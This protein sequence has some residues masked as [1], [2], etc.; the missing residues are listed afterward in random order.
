M[1]KLLACIFCLALFF[2]CG[3]KEEAV[4]S[5]E[6]HQQT[7]TVALAYKPKSFD[8]SKHTDSA[9][10]AVTKQIYSNLFSLGEKGEI[11]P[12]LAESYKIVSD[13]VLEIRLKKGILFHDGTEMKAEDVI[14]S[15]QRN[16]DSPVSH[17]LISPIQAMKKI[18]EYQIEI[19]SN[20]S[21]S[22]LL[23]NFTHGAVAITKEVPRNED[24][25]NLV[26]TGPFRVKLWGN[27]EKV[28]LEAFE[29]FFV[30][31]P[32]FQH[33][34][35]TT[36]PENANRVIA[37]ETGEIDLAYDIIP[38]DLPLLTEKKG[39]TYI[40]GLSFGSD[41]LSINTERMKDVDIRRALSLAID[42]TGI[43]EAVFEGKQNLASSILPPNVFG[44]SPTGI[45]FSQNLEEARKIMK[46]KGYDETHPLS[47]KM[48]IYEEPSRRQISEIIQA[49]LKEAFIDVEVVSL[50][51]SSFLQFTA[52]GKHD[53]LLGL[54]YVS[55]GDADYGYYPLLHSSSKGAPGN[56]AFYD[57]PK[58]DELLEDA[59]RTPSEKQRLKDY[60]EVQK[61]VEKELPIF[62]LFYKTY[63]IGIRNHISNLGFDPRGS[64]SLYNLQFSK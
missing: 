17:V 42:R 54:W 47:L 11:L 35:F 19:T 57:N 20:A 29:H 39:L 9:T 53:F 60:A 34:I 38:S 26:G 58:V 46:K 25:V 63:F 37:L 55:S 41:F 2:A 33:L 61:I 40:S 30:Q 13:T 7:V 64:H 1:K 6:N 22:I 3:K 43:N 51:V 44:Y 36:I 27:G 24:Q 15:L 49:N 52:Q 48:Y 59:R 62:P 18:D 21:P 45:T 23:H 32:N 4:V 31:K 16:L 56:R 8:P 14:A 28:E 10:M 12:E 5:A 50:E